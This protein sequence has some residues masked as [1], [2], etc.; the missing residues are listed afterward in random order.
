M[1]ISFDFDTANLQSGNYRITETDAFS[2]PTK[3]MKILERA[4]RDGNVLLFDRLKGREINAKGYIQASSSANL[5]TSMDAL[6]ALLMIGKKVLKITEDGAYRQWSEA[7]LQNVNISRG[8]QDI[9]HAAFSL[10]FWTGEPYAVDGNNDTLL[11]KT[12]LT[13][14]YSSDAITALGTYLTYPTIAM[15]LNSVSPTTSDQEIAIGNP[16]TTQQLR[17]VRTWA[18]GDVVSIDLLNKKVYVNGTLVAAEGR[19]PAWIPGSGNFE[20]VDSFTSRNI[21]YTV[22]AARKWL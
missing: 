3:D 1:A 8:A 21:D 16:S 14:G 4:R 20:Y 22:T 15:T 19:F 13:A 18:A 11:T 17:I 2:A 9:S 12:G 6:K 10:Q 5:K 7:V